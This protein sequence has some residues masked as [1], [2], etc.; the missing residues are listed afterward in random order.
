MRSN[1]FHTLWMM[2]ASKGNATAFFIDTKGRQRSSQGLGDAIW[3]G[4]KVVFL[5]ACV[6][7]QL[8]IVQPDGSNA[9]H[10]WCVAM[11]AGFSVRVIAQMAFLWS[12]GTS[13]VEVHSTLLS[14]H[15]ANMFG[16]GA[17]RGWWHR[18]TQ[19]R[20]LC[21]RC[22]VESAPNGRCG[23]AGSRS[24]CPGLLLERAT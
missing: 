13:W 9:R 23:V 5:L 7:M 22:K 2:M 18:A 1:G 10:T 16:Q 24:L 19:P 21:V 12:R 15:L 8:L 4:L 14:M 3:S 6:G 11:G 17:A 20:Q